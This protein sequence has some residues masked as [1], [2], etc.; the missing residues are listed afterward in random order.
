MPPGKSKD[1]TETEAELVAKA[2]RAVSH[3]NWIVGECAA[4]WTKKHAR[5]RTDADFAALVGLSAD[6]VYQRRRVWETFGDVYEQYS[7]L[8]WSHFYLAL[9]WSDAPECLQWAEENQATVAEMKAWR[10]AINGEDLT[11]EPEPDQWA[12]DPTISFVPSE[13]TAVRD[14]DSFASTGSRGSSPR[15]PPERGGEGSETVAAVAR[16]GE[17]SPFR[18]DAASP[19]PADRGGDVAVAERPQLSADKQIKKVTLALERMNQAL[20]A[21]LLKDARRLP[22]KQRQRFIKAVGELSSKAARLMS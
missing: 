5:G 10:R 3:C 12:G 20:T 18:K 8:K 22:E 15:K 19:A 16:E 1:V 9:N 2:Q 11:S 6:Q 17:Y 13:P 21:E 7:S 14:P 4:D